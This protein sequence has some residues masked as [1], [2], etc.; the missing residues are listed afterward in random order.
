MKWQSIPEFL[1]PRVCIVCHHP[2]DKHSLGQ[3]GCFARIKSFPAWISQANPH[4]YK[5]EC[6]TFISRVKDLNL[7]EEENNESV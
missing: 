3:G 2:L 7:P 1:E 5:C 4:M 6:E